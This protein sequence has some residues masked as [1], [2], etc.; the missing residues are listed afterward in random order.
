M[1]RVVFEWTE[2]STDDE[3]TC[4]IPGS[5]KSSFLILLPSY[6]LASV[7]N[8]ASNFSRVTTP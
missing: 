8:F 2:V 6:L 1:I 4:F 3:A 5:H 7:A